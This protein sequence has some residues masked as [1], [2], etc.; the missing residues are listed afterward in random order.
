MEG[1]RQS[2]EVGL[3]VNFAGKSSAQLPER[4]ILLPAFS[5][6][7][8]NVGSNHC[9]IE[10]LDQVGCWTGL[11][12]ELKK[13][14]HDTALAEAPEAF[15][16]AVPGPK[17][18]RA[19]ECDAIL[20]EKMSGA[21]AERLQLKKLMAKL[22]AGDMVVISAVDPSRGLGLLWANSRISTYGPIG[23]RAPPG[24]S[25]EAARSLH[26]IRG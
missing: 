11:G 12:Q 18:G 1:D 6:G 5:T 4:P 9:A 21:T 15:P 7:G 17:L 13:R 26:G 10:H 19:A 23:R 14:L 16:D 20:C 25:G 22:D 2:I 24:R 8:G 3:E